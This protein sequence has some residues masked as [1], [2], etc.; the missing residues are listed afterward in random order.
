[1]T[2][3]KKLIWTGAGALLAGLAAQSAARLFGVA[4]IR[5]VSG[6]IGIVFGLHPA[7]RAASLAPIEALRHE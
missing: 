7:L 6:G 4:N 3:K 2:R 5:R 1:M